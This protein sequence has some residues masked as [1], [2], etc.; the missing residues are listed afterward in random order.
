MKKL[1]LLLSIAF[2]GIA[3][4][5][6]T[7]LTDFSGNSG[8]TGTKPGA[9]QNLVSDGTFLYGMTSK[10]GSSDMGTIFK[11]KPD[12]TG[13]LQ[14]HSFTGAPDGKSPYG[15]LIYD[16]TFLYGMTY[17]G[18]TNDMGTIFKIMPDGT[19]YA[20]LLDFAGTTNGAAPFGGLI[21]D[22]TFLYGLTR[23]G[24]TNSLGTIFKIMPDGTGYVNLFNFA[25]AVSGSN[26]GGTLFYD[27]TFLYGTTNTG[28]TYSAGTIFKIK[29]DGTGFMKLLNFTGTTNGGSPQCTLISD[30]TFLFGMTGYGGTN[31]LGTL[32]KIM[33]DGTGYVKLLDFAGATNGATPR[34]S[35]IYDGTFLYGMT[36][37]GGTNNIGTLFKIMPDGTGYITVLNFRGA[38]NGSTPTGTLISDGTFLYG[39]TQ[40]GGTSN[41]GTFFK[42]MPNG[43]G[44]VVLLD[45]AGAANGSTPA[46]SLISDGTFLYGMTSL[47]GTNNLGTLFKIMPDGTGYAKLLDFAG[48]TNGSDPLGS[49]F[50]DGTFLY[51]MTSTG[52]TN[53][54]GTIFR[55]MPDGTGFLKLLDF[56]GTANGSTPNGSLISDGTFLYG[57]TR[58]GGI[59]N[60]AGTIFK[61]MPD[62]TGYVK[63]LD[64]ADIANGSNPLGSLSFDGTFLYGMVQFGGVN[65]SGTIFKIMPDGTGFLKLLDFAGV[66]NGRYPSGSLISD[67]T[68]LYGMTKYGGTNSLG[69]L[70]KIMMDGTGYVKMLD[71]TG[72]VNGSHPN[73]SLISDGTFFYGMTSDGGSPN[74]GT[75]FK[76]DIVTGINENDDIRNSVSIYPNPFTNEIKI[77]NSSIGEII[78]IDVNGKE[79]LKQ[80]T[81]TGETKIITENISAGFYLLN[82]TD[83]NKSVNIKLVK[84]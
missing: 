27:G 67:G 19:G 46:G 9:D 16:G 23:S 45:F 11:I 3:N 77:S 24:G 80:K 55:I 78:L 6:Y 65:N 62:G 12:G 73:G 83:R 4:A 51:G 33:P 32:F 30:G 75:V 53:N 74:A 25:G 20:K 69:T 81:F 64:L 21:S 41:L 13:L 71:F 8:F 82:Y 38:A 40:N 57:I 15:S 60:N 22:G 28:G 43:T 1:L 36:G 50:T 49:L 47:G 42:I 18:G 44:Y 17:L 52:G 7:L 68:L 39:M 48:T 63:L 35:L 34:G 10:G 29:P 31:S 70:F 56:A 76:L 54:L 2:C 26:P 59:N 84:F 79:I 61:I 72:A 37:A 58:E 66:A 14:L 5:Q